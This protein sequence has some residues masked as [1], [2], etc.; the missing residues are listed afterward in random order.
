MGGDTIIPK[1]EPRTG[2]PR[3]KAV[4]DKFEIVKA[5]F[6]GATKEVVT[7]RQ[8]DE[9]K[10]IVI[11]E[12][13]EFVTEIAKNEKALIDESTLANLEVMAIQ[14]ECE[15]NKEIKGNITPEVILSIMADML[16]NN[17]CNK[18]SSSTQPVTKVDKKLK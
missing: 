13:K 15:I 17:R 14:Q 4:M 6:G 2:E 11:A 1:G 16:E 8:Y 9:K 3:A 7:A 18:T 10:A 5:D 12:V